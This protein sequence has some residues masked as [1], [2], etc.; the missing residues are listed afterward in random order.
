VTIVMRR[1]LGHARL[2]RLGPLDGSVEIWCSLHADSPFRRAR[3]SRSSSSKHLEVDSEDGFVD[4][5][6]VDVD[7]DWVERVVR[8]ALG[9]DEAIVEQCLDGVHDLLDA[10]VVGGDQIVLTVGAHDALPPSVVVVVVGGESQS[11]GESPIEAVLPLLR[12]F[13]LPRD[14]DCV[15][16]RQVF[17]AILDIPPQPDVGTWH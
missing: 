4:E 6:P 15:K 13:M 2:T 7:L 8:Q 11:G 9:D 16:G 3:I 10:L 17:C 5:C 12:V 1:A 14:G